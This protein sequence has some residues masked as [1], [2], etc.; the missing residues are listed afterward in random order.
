MALR[1]SVDTSFLIDIQRERSKKEKPGGAAHRFLRRN[2][3]AELGLCVIALGELTEGFESAEHPIV[4]AVRE[5]HTILPVD[6][7]T[8][9]V[10]AR[11]TRRLR[12]E[13]RLIGANDLWIAA[14]SVR[15]GLPLLTSNPDDFGRVEG[16]ELVTYRDRSGG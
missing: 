9:A 3:D 8:A 15:H 2:P 14:C 11:N 10:Y 13:G 16:L 5:Q 1:L 6:E 7:D 4:V 12:R